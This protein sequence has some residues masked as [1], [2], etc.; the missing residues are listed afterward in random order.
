MLFRG[1]RCKWGERKKGFV[2]PKRHQMKHLDFNLFSV[3]DQKVES[4]NPVCRGYSFIVPTDAAAMFQSVDV[5]SCNM[6]HGVPLL[7]H[8]SRSDQLQILDFLHRARSNFR[9]G[10][11][12]ASH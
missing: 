11:L 8:V 10:W 5:A 12:P 6:G 7:C 9:A 1:A 4:S 3:R 2:V